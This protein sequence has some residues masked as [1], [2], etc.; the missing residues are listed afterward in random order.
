MKFR[1]SDRLLTDF[2]FAEVF[3]FAHRIRDRKETILNSG[4]YTLYIRKT[5]AGSRLG[6]SIGRKIVRRAHNRNRIKRCVREF[7]RLHKQKLRGDIVVKVQREPSKM[8]F[9]SLTQPLQLL[10]KE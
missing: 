4:P 1:K 7:F 2:E 5:E 6:L 10:I 3:N 9:N 8:S